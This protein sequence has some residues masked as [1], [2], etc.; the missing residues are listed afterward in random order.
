MPQGDIVANRRDGIYESQ[1][2]AGLRL[3]ATPQAEGGWAE[4]FQETDDAD[5][6]IEDDRLRSN[7]AIVLENCR[8]WMVKVCHGRV[9]ENGMVHLSETTRSALVGGFSDYLFPVIR[10]AFPTNVINELV[11]V[12]P[13]TRR[14]ATIMYW[15]Y[16]IGTTKGGYVRGQRVFDA[17]VG[18]VDTGFGYTSESIEAEAVTGVRSGSN[19][20]IVGTL[21]YNDGGGV[22]AN[23]V[24]LVVSQTTAGASQEYY[25]NG[26]GGFQTNA[27]GTTISSGSINYLTGVF[28]IV[29]TGDTFSADA[30]VAYYSWDSEGS[31]NLPE[32][33]IQITT[34]TTETERRAI[35]V[36]Y[37][38]EAMH[39]LMQ[40]MGVALEPQLITACAEEMNYEISRQILHQL[41]V[42]APTVATFPITGGAN[43]SQQQ[44]FGDIVYTINKASNTIWQR[45]QKATANWAVVDAGGATLLQSLPANLFTP[46]ANAGDVQ[47]M[48]FIGTLTGNI[49]VYK[50]ML[51]YNEPGAST[52][53]NILL[54]YKGNDFYKAGFVFAPYQ[55]LYTTDSIPTP[56]FTVAKGMAT[57]YA[58]KMVSPNFYAKILLAA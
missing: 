10:A 32:M 45:T 37:T 44:H 33:D 38:V 22:R 16:M 15:N 14:T 51:L 20:T 57:R 8:D 49:R 56:C 36:N 9:D 31:C 55:L 58:T 35:R 12:Q 5:L 17:N 23:S 21:K 52:Y 24:R 2:Q 53:G 30:I 3:A 34:S 39:D 6:R 46:A 7:T 26:N 27:A 48:Y 1:F 25:D 42:V 28:S 19:G 18:R 54:G 41:W 13:T 11:S 4:Y 40:E 47:G 43:F 50:D 29:I